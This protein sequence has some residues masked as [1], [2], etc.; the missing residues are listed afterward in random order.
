MW[1][2]LSSTLVSC[3]PLSPHPFLLIIT[4]PHLI[5]ELMILIDAPRAN[6]LP[7]GTLP[8]Y[9]RGCCCCWLQLH[10]NGSSNPSNL[11]QQTQIRLFLD[12]RFSFKWTECLRSG[13]RGGQ[14]PVCV[15]VPSSHDIDSH[16]FQSDLVRRTPRDRSWLTRR[17]KD[18]IACDLMPLCQNSEFPSKRLTQLSGQATWTR[19][20][21]RGRLWS[22]LLTP[23]TLSPFS[24]CQTFCCHLAGSYLLLLGESLL[25]RSDL[26]PLLI[27][28]RW[29]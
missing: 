29:W 1:P 28:P 7:W 15:C 6:A 8:L 11:Y 9:H 5:S 27:A 23:L 10:S 2:P 19:R 14:R 24:N 22:N 18:V 4:P 3:V 12:S 26:G 16:R 25:G 13:T 17:P 21:R 20:S